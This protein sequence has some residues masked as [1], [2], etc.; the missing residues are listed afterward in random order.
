MK[1]LFNLLYLNIIVPAFVGTIL[2]SSCATNI[3]KVQ[4]L[5]DREN[6]PGMIGYDVEMLYTE[7]GRL[8]FKIIAPESHYFQFSKEPYNEFPKGITV[9]NYNDSL[10]IESSIQ[11]NYAIFYEEKKLWNA[12]YDVVA[13]NSKGETLNTEQLFWDQQAKR[14]YTHD[15][16]KITQGDDI[17]FG[18]GLESDESMD[19]W[20]IL[21]PSG[22]VY[23]RQD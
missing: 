3:E 13:T 6:L 14:I 4:E 23:V 12:R 16:V 21:K 11:A 5:A 1:K 7:N 19:N 15:M 8:K 10:E 9:Y 2:F 20:E 18:E 22:S 17:L